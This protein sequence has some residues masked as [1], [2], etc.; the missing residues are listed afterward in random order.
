MT[1]LSRLEA[2]KER[3]Q[4]VKDYPSPQY[5]K[6]IRRYRELKELT[7]EQ[8]AELMDYSVKGWEK[9]ETGENQVSLE[10]LEKCSYLLD[11]SVHYEAGEVIFS[12]SDEQSRRLIHQF[13]KEWRQQ[14]SPYQMKSITLAEL[15]QLFHQLL[16]T[17]YSGEGADF[18][19]CSSGRVSEALLTD[20]KG[21][22]KEPNLTKSDVVDGYLSYGQDLSRE[23]IQS[24]FKHPSCLTCFDLEF[25]L[26]G[27]VF[28]V[29]LSF[30]LESEAIFSE[31]ALEALEQVQMGQVTHQRLRDWSSVLMANEKVLTQTRISKLQILDIFES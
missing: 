21:F 8:F 7:R 30:E 17:K 25:D 18:F 19:F 31:V 1:K 2:L 20:L 14:L 13:L 26:E 28:N 22:S 5:G 6:I 9:L 10:V 29:Y 23:E 24:F 16:V 27:S 15:K 3:V 4:D 12:H 11:F